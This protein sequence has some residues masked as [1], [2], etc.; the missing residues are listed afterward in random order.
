MDQSLYKGLDAFTE[1]DS[2]F[3]F[4]RKDETSRLVYSLQSSRLTILYGARGVGKTSLLRAGVAEQLRQKSQTESCVVLFDDWSKPNVLENLSV[5]IDRSV[6]RPSR[7]KMPRSETRSFA[8][9]CASWAKRLGDEDGEL[10]IL[11]DQFDD[12][13]MLNPT[14]DTH[15]GSFDREFATAVSKRGLPVNFVI[16]VRDDLLASLDR[17]QS[18]IPGLFS[19]L[20]RLEPLT[21]AQAT[22]AIESPVYLTYNRRYPDKEIWIEPELVS[23]VLDSVNLGSGPDAFKGSEW[24]QGQLFDAGGLQLAM[25]AIS[26]REIGIGSEV[27]KHDTYKALGEL[28]DI[29]TKYVDASFDGFSERERH[30]SALIFDYLTT[31][32]GLVVGHGLPDLAERA[33][34]AEE[35]IKTLTE[36]LRAR[37]LIVAS[38]VGK[39][40]GPLRYEVAHASLEPTMRK[41]VRAYFAQKVT[42]ERELRA[43]I[44]RASQLFEQ[45]SQLDG[46]NTIIG[47][48]RRWSAGVSSLKVGKELEGDLRKALDRIV[49]NLRQTGQ[50]QGYTGAV[51]SVIYCRDGSMI[52]TGAED[53]SVWLWD[54]RSPGQ[55]PSIL[56]HNHQTWIWALRASIDDKWL[57]TG[58]DDGTV[59]LWS[60]S[61]KGFVFRYAIPSPGPS[62]L[63]RCLSFNRAS[64]L[65]AIASTDGLVRVWDLEKEAVLHEFSASQRPVR[66]VEFSP[67]GRSLATGADDGAIGLWDLGGSR[68]KSEFKHGAAAVW[69]IRFHPEAERLASCSED[70][71]IRLWDL[72]DGT[73]IRTLAGHTSWVLDIQFSSDGR[74]LASASEDGT[75]RLWD[76]EGSQTEVFVHGAPVHG[77]CF[78]PDDRT[79]ATAAADCKVS[80]W[81]VCDDPKKL[82]H[83]KKPILLDVSVSADGTYAIGATDE[84]VQIW[85]R[86]GKVVQTLEGHGSWVMCVIFHPSDSS[87]LATSSLDGTARLWNIKG[88][89]PPEIFAPR[90]GPVW[91]VAFSPDGRFLATGSGG[92]KISCWD[93]HALKKP[94]NEPME[95]FESGR[96]SVWSIR[97]SPDGKWIT[98]GCQ[99][100]T[101]LMRE[102]LGKKSK[103]ELTGVH[104]GQVL[105]LSFNSDERF[106]YLASSS[107]EGRICVWDLATEEHRL[108]DLHA[109]V[110]SVVFS[111]DG[112]FLASGSVNRS[113]YLWDIAWERLGAY[114]ADGPI[115]G[116][117]FSRD[118]KLLAASCSD[119]TVRLWPVIN[120]TFETLLAKARCEWDKALKWIPDR[121][122]WAANWTPW[123]P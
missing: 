92:G 58:S 49:N 9:D 47:A 46:L 83:S 44:E 106:R 22:E 32:G 55:A 5:A 56:E 59:F 85:D 7:Q 112:R 1:K 109:P 34:V 40:I 105:S 101:I 69:G 28:F 60:A 97:F 71:N 65:L 51:S 87:L 6:G 3:F 30:L 99:D 76:E 50:L 80:L 21:R 42:E 36:K 48:S 53:G 2:E 72:N 90:D 45:T 64:S 79:L 4:G 91:S 23:A 93:L 17:Y 8:E 96:G 43:Q 77:V 27:F 118:S 117:A 29:T 110:W 78:S 63:V 86:N 68:R 67:D 111:P 108:L 35:E 89:G 24:A 39:S 114:H 95:Q 88:D 107:S 103:K 113:V 73:F 84:D 104:S 94:D 66:C 37:K 123:A 52:A 120:E 41:K 33:G 81:N 11:L 19:S 62:V 57:A 10:F 16:A 38:G 116:L 102:L 115:R 14:A 70:H 18:M 61:D 74:L 15:P 121:K 20:I 119:G 100:G 98:A 25:K 12:Y 54:I 122:D 13:L 31:P 75:A 82:G 26:E